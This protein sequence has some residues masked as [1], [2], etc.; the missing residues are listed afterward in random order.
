MHP[1]AIVAI[2]LAVA[3]LITLTVGNLLKLWLDDDTFQKLTQKPTEEQPQQERSPLVAK[4]INAYPFSLGEDV[5]RVYGAPAVSVPLNTPDGTLLYTSD[6]AA[7]LGLARNEQI[8][9]FETVSE[10]SAYVSY[11]S[12]V[13][14]PQAFMSQSTD[15]FYA[16]SVQEAAL[17]REALRTGVSELLLRDMPLTVEN[18]DRIALYLDNLRAAADDSAIGVAIPLSVARSEGG[19][20]ILGV[21]EQHC[22]FL[23]LDVT[24]EVITDPEEVEGGTSPAAEALLTD[25]NYYLTQYNMR[26]LLSDTQ[27]NLLS[28]LEM[29]GHQNYQVVA[30]E[31]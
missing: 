20:E 5:T 8:P 16:S 26:L 4:R 31:P 18:L 22:D 15:V 13:F 24:D 25:C 17:V 9:L 6:V 12:G 29:Q 28:T 11:I 1:V 21:L 7:H 27:T 3:V 2:C 30:G 14:Y 19:W 23:V 10:L